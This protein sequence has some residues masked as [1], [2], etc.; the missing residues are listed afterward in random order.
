MPQ[1]GRAIHWKLGPMPSTV[2]AVVKLTCPD[3]SRLRHRTNSTSVVAHLAGYTLRELHQIGENLDARYPV[4]YRSMQYLIDSRP[5][6]V[7]GAAIFPPSCSYE[8]ARAILADV[9]A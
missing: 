9:L 8:R 5:G 6:S 3:P 4:L 2:E 1:T 7:N